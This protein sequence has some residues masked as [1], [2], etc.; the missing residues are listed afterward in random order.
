MCLNA[1]ISTVWIVGLSFAPIFFA[2]LE[3]HFRSLSHIRGRYT[4]A[5]IDKSA[6][7]IQ[8]KVN[9]SLSPSCLLYPSTHTYT[10]PLAHLAVSAAHT[11]TRLS[12]LIANWFIWLEWT[13]CEEK[14][15]F[16]TTRIV[17]MESYQNRWL[18][19]MV[20][21]SLVRRSGFCFTFFS[22]RFSLVCPFCVCVTSF[23]CR[24]ASPRERAHSFNFCL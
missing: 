9:F 17:S 4:S 24:R 1:L 15:T 19:S 2:C 22:L 13:E 18:D 11:H 12:I 6:I 3:Q 10:H 8:H 20:L 7:D 16:Q 21:F 5:S 23:V 14:S